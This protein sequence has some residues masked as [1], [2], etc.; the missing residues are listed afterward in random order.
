MAYEIETK[1]GIVIRGIP[2]TVKPDDPSIKAKVANARFQR[3]AA[4]PDYRKAG[5]MALEGMTG[6]EK[7]DAGVGKA[8]TDTGRGIRQLG[9]AALDFVAPRSPTL[10][11]LVTGQDP[12]RSAE[13]MRDYAQTRGRDAALMD[14]GAGMAGNVAGNIAMTLAP[15][16]ALKAGAMMTRGAQVS[17]MLA[18]AGS[19]L[20]APRSIGGA[21]ALGAALGAAQPV[22]APGEREKNT[23]FGGAAGAVIPAAVKGVQL[24]RAMT[25]PFSDKGQQQIIGGML[26]RA[27]G[28]EAD[29]VATRLSDAAKPF[30]GPSQP[31]AGRSTMG[32]IV[33]GSLPTT[34]QVAGNA[35]I[36]ATE[37]AASAVDPSVTTAY[38]NR[39]AQQNVART[40]AL[41]DMTGADGL[42]EFTAANRDATANA[43][44]GQAFGKAID[45]T[46]D[47]ATGQKVSKAVQAGIK[48]EITKLLNR[49][50]I[51]DAM[52]DAQRLALE[53]GKKIS[54][55]KGS[56]EG[57]HYVKK[58]LDDKLKN[59]TPG[60]NE[61]RT[62]K[63]TQER[64]LT[65]M[66][67][68]SPDYA[69]ARQVFRDMSRPLNQM[70][71]AAEIAEKSINKLTGTLQPAA[72]ARAF[73]DDAAKRGS[74]FR[75]ATLEGTFDPAQ[76]NKLDAILEDVRRVNF[77]QTAGRGVGSDTV[78]KLAY[79]NLIDSAGI[80]TWLRAMA[81]AQVAG[82]VMGRGAD[83]L[84]GRANREMAA[85]LAEM[86]LDPQQSAQAMQL[87][88]QLSR[89]SAAANALRAG[90]TPL[91][92]SAPALVNAQKQ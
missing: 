8:I 43:L 68:I 54:D 5:D 70:D 60:S 34:A 77:A 32:E 7:F 48:G 23:L 46:R 72:Y 86:L 44:Y 4:N 78:Q 69:A 79:S 59:A 80:P 85:R 45:L 37:R 40:S 10:S 82:N 47:A 15:G 61:M 62:I 30:V 11:G 6:V 29:D 50:S 84:Y 91:L 57:L 53:E 26:R 9:R 33:P 65:L 75:R 27:A 39:M 18:S 28:N 3:D 38:A 22:A 13:D 42:R 81:P 31:G 52:K 90:A 87:A 2:D 1:D 49:P 58:A 20:L 41:Q 92:M 12:S 88:A 55:P 76:I 67:R 21:A 64:L 56:L 66:D 17:P 35:G 19:A 63:A 73:S 89:P 51:Q 74:G 14:S 83:A 16:G 25:Q 36:A 24:A 71:T